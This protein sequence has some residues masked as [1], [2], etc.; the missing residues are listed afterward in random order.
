VDNRATG[1]DNRSVAG[2]ENVPRNTRTPL[3][4]WVGLCCVLFAATLGPRCAATEVLES[5]ARAAFLFHITQFVTWPEGSFAGTFK[6]GVLGP[7]PFGPILD[8]LVQGET[9]GGRPIQVKRAAS[10]AELLDCETIYVSSGARESV[11]EIASAVKDRPVLLIGETSKFLDRGGMIRIYRSP[12]RKLKLQ[13]D[14]GHARRASLK[15]SSQ[16]L[17]ISDVRRG[18]DT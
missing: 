6:I 14:L 8:A 13:V 18:S 7:D 17:R 11:A 15:I 12:E 5:N 4:A 10:I 9:V 16:L 2:I 1:P 3:R